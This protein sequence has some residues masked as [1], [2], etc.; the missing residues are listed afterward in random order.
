MTRDWKKL[1]S[2]NNDDQ[3]HA[4]FGYS[5]TAMEHF[6]N[7]RNSGHVNNY[8]GIGFFGDAACGDA[9]EFTIRLNEDDIITDAGYLVYGCAGA[10]A[11]TSMVSVLA[12]GRDISTALKISPQ[13]VI[14]ALGGFPEDKV[15]C[16]LLGLETLRLAI[17]DALFG[18][19]LINQG[20]VEDYDQYRQFRIEGKI[21]IDLRPKNNGDNTK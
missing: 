7:P 6:I 13:D 16:S 5:A 4:D 8:H 18:R 11:T 3:P 19:Q 20:K 14:D 12:K 17:A 21:R 1:Y 2:A 15:H 10:I 9:L